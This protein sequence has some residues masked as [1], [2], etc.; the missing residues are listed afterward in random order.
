MAC[1][2]VVLTSENPYM[3]ENF[4]DGKSILFYNGNSMQNIDGKLKELLDDESLRKS[5]AKNGR[6][7]VM[8]AHTW[9]NRAA[10]LIKDLDPMVKR[11]KEADSNP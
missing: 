5:I 1:G 9:D 10:Q 7:L 6:D 11:I 4:Q 8:H 2:A 3:S